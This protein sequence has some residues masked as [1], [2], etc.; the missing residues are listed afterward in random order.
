MKV[1]ISENQFANILEQM[2]IEYTPDKIDEFVQEGIKYIAG[3]KKLYEQYYNDLMTVSIGEVFQNP[4]S[5]KNILDKLEKSKDMIDKVSTKYYNAVEMYNIG[6][7]PD[8]VDKLDRIYSEIDVIQYDIDQIEDIYRAI[9]DSVQ[10]YIEW[11]Q[12]KI[13]RE[14]ERNNIMQKIRG[15]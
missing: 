9:Y 11:N 8:N 5:I 15:F 2:K 1:I 13:E 12:D 7:Y 14:N 3:L 10:H 6:E 4:N